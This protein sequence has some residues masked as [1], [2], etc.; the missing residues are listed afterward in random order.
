C[1]VG[2][3]TTCGITTNCLGR[4]CS[5]FTGC[6]LVI[7]RAGQCALVQLTTLFD[8][9]PDTTP[10]AARNSKMSIG[11]SALFLGRSASTRPYTQ[12]SLLGRFSGFGFSN[13]L[14]NLRQ[15]RPLLPKSLHARVGAT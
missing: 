1:V 12:V 11:S 15:P 6:V 8:Y 10:I 4:S 14:H 3:L 2:R 7:I 13:R 5:A 9:V